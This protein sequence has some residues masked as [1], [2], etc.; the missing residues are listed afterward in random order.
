MMEELKEEAEEQ[1]IDLDGERDYE[2]TYVAAAAAA[3][4]EETCKEVKKEDETAT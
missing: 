4:N 3:D 2:E 1:G